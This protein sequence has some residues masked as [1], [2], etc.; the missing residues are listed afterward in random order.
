MSSTVRIFPTE[1]KHSGI[2][3]LF[4]SSFCVSKIFVRIVFWKCK[5]HDCFISF[6]IL[7]SQSE[8]LSCKIENSQINVDIGKTKKPINWFTRFPVIFGLHLTNRVIFIE[9]ESS[10]SNM[11]SQIALYKKIA[12]SVSWLVSM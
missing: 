6:N 2:L 3:N 8:N 12:M 10:S 7:S 5:W 11:R 1:I 4:S 9:W